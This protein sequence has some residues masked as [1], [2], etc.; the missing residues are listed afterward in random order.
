M[1]SE[2]QIHPYIIRFTVS[3]GIALLAI[4]LILELMDMDAR[5]SGSVACWPASLFLF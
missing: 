5:S 1:D 2:V 4:G 3:Y